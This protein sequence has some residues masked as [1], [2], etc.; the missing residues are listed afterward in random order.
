MSKVKQAQKSIF[1]PFIVS[2]GVSS[3]LFLYRVF[4]SHSNNYWYLN[5]NLFLGWLPLL[6]S[7]WLVRWLRRKSWFSIKGVLLT[8]LWL[9]F[10]PNS[11]YL[12][13]DFV[14]LTP[15][16]EISLLFD[17]VMFMTFAWNGLL[18]GFTSVYM[19]HKELRKR[20]PEKISTSFVACTLVLSSFAIYLGRYLTWNTWDLV[21][22]PGGILL[23]ISDRIV[24]P[25]AYPNTFTVTI[26]FSFVLM[27]LY[28]AVYKLISV[29]KSS[30]NN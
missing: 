9:G 7:Y 19:I 8:T 30:S 2:S 25:T 15:T 6:F 26:L 13:T 18:L 24:K 11:F 3:V 28:Y 17:A 14:H 5:W 4:S 29:I 16:H 1:W 12:V 23:D 20:L 10:L 27:S 21:V 22:N